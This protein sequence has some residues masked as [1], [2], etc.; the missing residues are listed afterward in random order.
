MV[1]G[2]NGAFGPEITPPADATPTEAF[3]AWTGRAPR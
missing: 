1:R 2:A 3:V